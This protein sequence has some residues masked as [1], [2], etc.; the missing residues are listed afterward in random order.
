M[1]ISSCINQLRIYAHAVT[2]SPDGSFQNVGDAQ[3]R[4]NLPQVPVAAAILTDRGAADHFQV[5]HLGQAG[6]DVVLNSVCKISVLL[7]VAQILKRQDRDTFV[8]NTLWP[9]GR[10]HVLGADDSQGGDVEGPRKDQ[11]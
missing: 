3:S 7:V 5:R 2:G 1:G 9:S 10:W 11:R 4:A 6:K 8:R